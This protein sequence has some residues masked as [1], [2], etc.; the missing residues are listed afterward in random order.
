MNPN[1]GNVNIKRTISKYVS[2]IPFDDTILGVVKGHSN[3]EVSNNELLKTSSLEQRYYVQAE[4]TNP[5]YANTKIF[6]P[7]I[8]I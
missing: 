4:L 5:F 2:I 7:L 6:L 1:L 8:Q 3:K